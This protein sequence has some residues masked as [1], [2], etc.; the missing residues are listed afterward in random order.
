MKKIKN[1]YRVLMLLMLAGICGV[2]AQ[3]VD[4]GKM[5]LDTDYKIKQYSSASGYYEVEKSG[6]LQVL[7]APGSYSFLPFYDEGHSLQV[8]VL[9]HGYIDGGYAYYINVNAGETIYFFDAFILDECVVR[10]TMDKPIE[11]VAYYPDPAESPKFS[12]SGSGRLEI[13]FNQTCS[14]KGG[15]I[16]ANGNTE[17]MTGVST[18]GAYLN[19]DVYSNIVRMIA[20]GKITYGD[21]FTLLLTGV[22]ASDTPDNLYNGDGNLALTYT[23]AD[24]PVEMIRYKDIDGPFLSYFLPGDKKGI[25]EMYFDQPINPSRVRATLMYGDL[26]AAL[27]G[28]YYEEYLSVKFNEDNTILTV[29][30]TGKV[31][32]PSD[33]VANGNDYGSMTLY[34]SN[35][36]SP[37]GQ[38]V[39]INEQ[40]SYGG[41]VFLWQY[42][43]VES[44]IVAEFTPRSGSSIENRNEIEI[45]VKNYDQLVHNGVKFSWPDN[46]IVVPESEL[47]FERDQDGTAVLVKVP[48]AAKTA[49]DVK[50]TFADMMTPDGLDHTLALT[51]RYNVAFSLQGSR[52]TPRSGSNLNTLSEGSEVIMAIDKPEGLGFV[53]LTIIDKANP[54]EPMVDRLELSINDDNYF[55]GTLPE[56]LYFY[57]GHTYRFDVVAYASVDAYENGEEPLGEDA[58]ECNGSRPAYIESATQ[59]ENIDPADGTEITDTAFN[60]FVV[61]FDSFASVG[62][63][64]YVR[65]ENG[66]RH[67]VRIELTGETDVDPDTNKT[68]CK[69][70][71]LT[72][73]HDEVMSLGRNITLV[74]YCTGDDGNVIPGNTGKGE[75]SHYEFNY[76]LSFNEG[77]GAIETEVVTSEADAE[78]YNLQG[79]RV[80]RATAA[81]G[82]YIRRAG[83]KADKV[84]IK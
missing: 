13:Q 25:V 42:K 84:V 56:N 68:Y 20:A 61:T 81:P 82:L 38:Y 46:E 72:M 37:D 2:S 30:L 11:V 7:I 63:G 40:G 34:V 54:G 59:L 23:L 45:Y 26:D 43:E 71:T 1:L 47:K 55:A 31:R 17:T 22:A 6:V 80:D 73:P 77:V 66:G 24:K 78:Y 65:D 12:L 3:A 57:N 16:S 53:L 67:N 14:V 33:M 28:N 5:E 36:F 44:N 83:D 21:Q 69:E 60:T 52:C 70:F 29:D 62:A 76:V 9:N 49:K 64:T 39:N 4:F 15:Y 75:N 74:I 32:R 35:L 19:V 79:V 41:R 18:N 8:N 48:E 27:A 58:I 51:A 10:L 50:V